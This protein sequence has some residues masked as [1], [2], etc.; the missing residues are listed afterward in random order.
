[1]DI[2]HAE[3]LLA[4]LERLEYVIDDHYDYATDTG[5]DPWPGA[6]ED[7]YRLRVAGERMKYYLIGLK[8]AS[9]V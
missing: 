3:E 6:G 4:L 8:E 9:D 7:L 5:E 2:K 1:M